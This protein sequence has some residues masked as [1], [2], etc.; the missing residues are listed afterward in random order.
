MPI[1]P[2]QT[3][4]SVASV[5]DCIQEH[6]TFKKEVLKRGIT[7]SSE[8]NRLGL[9][10]FYPMGILLSEDETIYKYNDDDP[11]VLKFFD[12]SRTA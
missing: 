12:A 3:G 8:F 11:F 7:V 1:A 9:R 6:D 4:V 2:D 5:L 10:L